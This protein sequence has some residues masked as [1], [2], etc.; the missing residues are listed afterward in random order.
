MNVVHYGHPWS[1]GGPAVFRGTAFEIESLREHGRA[2]PRNP[3][4]QGLVVPRRKDVDVTAADLERIDPA[5]EREL[6]ALRHNLRQ[7]QHGTRELS[8]ARAW[9]EGERAG[10]LDRLSRGR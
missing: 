5:D 4:G 8:E 6:E 3:H 2:G 9:L 7:L 1:E 10:L